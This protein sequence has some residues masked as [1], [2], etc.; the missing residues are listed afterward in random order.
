MR[1][2]Y[3]PPCVCGDCVR[4]LKALRISLIFPSSISRCSALPRPPPQEYHLRDGGGGWGAAR[5]GALARGCGAGGT[6]RVAGW[7]LCRGVV[8]RRP[9]AVVMCKRNAAAVAVYHPHAA[10]RLPLPAGW[11]MPT[12]SSRLCRR[13]TTR[14]WGSVG[15]SS[16]GAWERKG[17]RVMGGTDAAA[18]AS[19]CLPLTVSGRRYLLSCT[20]EMHGSLNHLP[21]SPPSLLFALQRRAE[22]A[23]SDC[24]GAGAAARSAAAG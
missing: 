14:K 12:T 22:A 13:D 10:N 6:V 4:L 16:G 23:D 15:C 18:S 5:A 7:A 21:S 24:T 17:W 2:D 11:P 20:S 8:H 9:S 19:S 3:V 1:A